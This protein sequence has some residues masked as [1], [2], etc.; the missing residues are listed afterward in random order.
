MTRRS[1]HVAG[2]LLTTLVLLAGAG[3]E[4]WADRGVAVDVGRIDL[5]GPVRPGRDHAL[6][7]IT[8]RNPGSETA[9]YTW[10]VQPVASDRSSPSPEWFELTPDTVELA[11]GETR[12]TEVVLTP[13]RGAR[14]GEYEALVAA[15]L[16]TT[17]QGAQVGAAAAT[18][19]T[20]SVA[21]LGSG[22]TVPGWLWASAAV[23]GAVAVLAIPARRY[24]IRIERRPD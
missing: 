1:V 15:Q 14:P 3:V 11:P 20:F 8:V 12:S 23:V 5:D 19:L 9:A 2:L 17:G 16:T 10:S 6:P 22:M 4:A 7:A 18:R 21:P 13:D 24:R